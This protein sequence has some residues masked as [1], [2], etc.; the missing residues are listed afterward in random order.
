MFGFLRHVA[1][2]IADAGSAAF[3]WTE[4]HWKTIAVVAASTVVFVGV[5]ALTGGLGAPALVA[6]G[7]GGFASGVTGY[8]LSNLLDHRPLTLTGALSAG[9]VSTVVTIATAGVLRAA[10]PFVSRV[11]APVAAAIPDAVTA[12]VPA[13]VTRTVGSTAVGA[14]LGAGTQFVENLA[15][16]RPAGE[17]VR[18]AALEGG[19]NGAFM[20]PAERLVSV[21]LSRLPLEPPPVGPGNGDTPQ[22]KGFVQILEGDTTVGCST[23]GCSEEGLCF[24]AGTL[25]VTDGGLRPIESIRPG[26]RVLAASDRTLAQGWRHVVRVFRDTTPRVVSITTEALPRR[27]GRA[28]RVRRPKAAASEATDPPSPIRCTEGHRFMVAGRGWT[29]AVEL[30]R[31]DFLVSAEGEPVAVLAVDARARVARTFNLEVEEDHTYFVAAVLDSPAVWVHNACRGRPATES[32]ADP[33]TAEKATPRTVPVPRLPDD[34]LPVPLLSQPDGYS[35]GNS[36]ATAIGYYFQVFDG[37]IKDTYR[38]MET[39]WKDGTEPQNIAD[40]MT[41]E[42][43]LKA[44]YLEDMTLDDLRAALAKGKPVIVDLQA[45]RDGSN[46]QP[47]ADDW[48]DGHYVVLVGM[49]GHYAYFM[50]PSGHFGYSYMPLDE[51]TERWHDTLRDGTKK[52]GMGIVVE[53]KN[54]LPKGALVRIDPRRGGNVVVAPGETAPGDE[55][56]VER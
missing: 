30:R 8:A 45:W 55:P 38:P 48:K 43:G 44:D 21:P 25:V 5:T 6:L 11:A 10:S 26:E 34:H 39:T 52:W 23:G 7:S 16:G 17:N 56:D 29:R 19:L 24:L 49:D 42:W 51:L 50:D 33:T 18:E 2:A 12:A 35:C 46:E 32:P 1:G 27:A 31:G 41:N 22:L 15:T 14:G 28:S 37:A 3:H 53:G 47:W 4:D 20:V 9:L 54:P 40:Y 36:S 13:V